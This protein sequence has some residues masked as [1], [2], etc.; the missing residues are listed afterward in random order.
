MTGGTTGLRRS[1]K[2]LRHIT[3]TIA[4]RSRAGR[5]GLRS[6]GGVKV[7]RLRNGNAPARGV[8]IAVTALLILV[9]SASWGAAG[10]DDLAGPLRGIAMQAEEGVG[11][12]AAGQ[13]LL[14]VVQFKS[15]IAATASNLAAHGAKVRFR[16]G[17]QVEA[18]VP[19]DSLLDIANMPDVAQVRPPAF[20]QPCQGFGATRSEG[21]RL[22]GAVPF[23][24]A[25]ITGNGV[26]VAIIDTGFAG[27]DSAEIP[28]VADD[29]NDVVSFR[30]GGDMGSTYH[31]TAVAEIAADMAPS[32]DFT[33][34]AVDTSQSAQSAADYVANQDFDVAC[35]SLDL[36]GG[37]YDG[38]HPLSQ[39]IDEVRDRGVFW[40]NAAGN[41]AER[42]W[43]G[44]WQ[45]RDR[46]G[47]NEFAVGD[48]SIDVSL[49][50][51]NY[52]AYLSWYQT[53]GT[54]TNRDYDL[55]LYD[56][57]DTEISRSGFTQNGDD[58]PMDVLNA[59]ISTAGTYRLRIEY[60]SGPAD[61]VESFQLFSVLTDLEEAHQVPESSITIPADADGSYA[62]G[63]TR[64]ATVSDPAQ[65]PLEI[66][67]LEEFSSQ[68]PV[69][70]NPTK[71][72]PDLVA[73]NAVSTSLAAEGFSPFFGTSAAAPH[74]AGAA[75]LL[76]SEDQLRTPEELE[77]VLR[78]QAVQVG[79]DPVPNNQVGHGRLNM[80]VGAD[81]RPPTITIS[82]PENGSNITTRLPSIIAFI[83]DDGSGVDPASITVELNGV[84][85]FDGS[86]VDDITDFYDDRT[87]QFTFPVPDTLA[88]TNH[89]V[90]IT[91][92]D[93]AGNE[94]DPAVTNFR[95]S[96]PTFPAGVSI[97]SFPYRDLAVTDPAAILGIPASELAMVRWWPLDTTTDKYH[98]YPDVRASLTPP[99][100]QQAD[101][102]DRT[103][104]YPPA[105]LGFFLSIPRQAV[106]D[107]QGQPLQD[108][109]STH[110]R[111][112]R[113]Q[114]P[115]RGWNLIG[116]PYDEPVGWGTV[117][118]ETG[119]ERYDL[120]EAI[121]EGVTEGVLFEFVQGIG[122]NPGYYD[123]NPEPTAAIMDA[124]KGYWVHVN[125][126]VRARVYSTGIGVAS[127]SDVSDVPS[128]D[129]GW[130]MTL[131][132]RAGDFI[133][134][135]NII[136]VQA[137]ASAGYDPQWDI[138]EPPAV[139]DGLRVAMVRDG[140][141]DNSGAYARDVRGPGDP[142]EWEVQVACALP[143]QQVELS[144]PNLN[145]EVPE[146][147][148]LVLEDVDTGKTVYMRTSSGFRFQTGDEGAVRHLRIS[149][150]DGADSLAVNTM[151]AQP[152][153]GGAMIT[154]SVSSPAEVAVEVMNIA[155]RLIKRF[156][157][158]DVDGGAQETVSWNGVSDRGS[159]VPSGRYIVRLTALAADGQTVQ[160]IRPFSIAR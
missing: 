119:G 132:A 114:Q 138:P 4:A 63:A 124:R 141:G 58:P 61:P 5:H 66:D 110:I 123:F 143:N 86:Q 90:I 12:S 129:E 130:T 91:V 15:P 112:Y 148:R 33:L 39:K 26:K 100:T 60:V 149:V 13:D 47:F 79:D 68:G 95:V 28:V 113:G 45:D 135:R 9:S 120:A 85:V 11:P 38:S 70:G 115:P 50:P 31:G 111:L 27:Y 40:V 42:H 3:E 36:L 142:A 1:R 14:V 98:F 29:P 32:A 37:P 7:S 122:D 136:G 84:I 53:A 52:Q 17:D 20:L 93:N 80:R 154:Y 56:Q 117:Q 150:A 18:F 118:F 22:V 41:S 131:Q 152:A 69:V 104:P 23:H 102:D 16:H 106:L 43:M 34:I 156:P 144:W 35:M 19:A 127:D 160:A 89:T 24:T 54:L 10:Y 59:Q 139:A 96:A 116:N 147:V 94:A 48:E 46:D 88:R 158:R 87:G 126:D 73:P 128:A 145:A 44:D 140:W 151:S 76:L 121:D 83:S 137:T 71:I 64:G 67:E 81:S 82:Y 8:V 57:S 159:A 108:I 21:V 92:A 105:G 97:V 133:D 55:V 2:C 125:E 101:L 72:K 30:A 25:G 75:A 153:S 77:T 157:A 146:D 6:G 107:I 155:G 51:G 134:P 65:P 109:P 49:N 99:D 62:V 103:V 74:V 78:T